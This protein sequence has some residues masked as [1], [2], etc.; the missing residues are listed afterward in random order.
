[1]P[2][3]YAL[4]RHLNLDGDPACRHEF[5][6][7]SQRIPRYSDAAIQKMRE[8]KETVDMDEVWRQHRPRMKSS[9]GP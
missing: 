9:P 6:F 2:K 8:A 4:R 3:G 5:V 1:L 7:D